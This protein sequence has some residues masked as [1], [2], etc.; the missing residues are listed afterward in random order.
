ML[1]GQAAPECRSRLLSPSR[2]PPPLALC[3]RSP[4]PLPTATPA[5][6]SA[7][8]PVQP[9]HTHAQH[10]P[11]PPA[12]SLG[13]PCHPGHA[14]RTLEPSPTALPQPL[15]SS[16]WPPIR[17]L[18]APL[19]FPFRKPPPLL[20]PRAP[21]SSKPE[22]RRAASKLA[23]HSGDLRP[24]PTP[25]RRALPHQESKPSINSEFAPPRSRAPPFFFGSGQNRRHR[26]RISSSEPQLNSFLREYHL[27]PL[28]LTPSLTRAL[29]HPRS[30][31]T[32]TS[33]LHRRLPSPDHS[34]HPPP[35][36]TT[37]SCSR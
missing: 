4:A 9:G 31:S 24:P 15:F 3:H 20:P 34:G 6:S 19:A 17:S 14:A 23:G 12:L 32:V 21:F 29:L 13:C 30:L 25:S 2:T 10:A 28:F 27:S 8:C 22:C 35:S 7:S 16:P 18:G 37:Q 26:R 33:Q 1:P 11:L 36:P 5:P